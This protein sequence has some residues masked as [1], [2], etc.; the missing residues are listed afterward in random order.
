MIGL[1]NA[2]KT[3]LLRVLAVSPFLI[4]IRLRMSE[5]ELTTGG[6]G[7]E[8]TVECVNVKLR[9]AQAGG[10]SVPSLS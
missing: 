10:T 8:F 7:G 5:L 2:G 6:Q 4:R 9:V 1:Q 3:S